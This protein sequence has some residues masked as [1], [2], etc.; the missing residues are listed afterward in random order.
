MA[1]GLSV[2]FTGLE[3]MLRELRELPPQ[4]QQRVIRGATAKGASVL[5]IEAVARAPDLAGPVKPTK[6]H[7][8]PGT[9]KRSIYQTRIPSQCTPTREV[10][11]VDVRKGKRATKSINGKAVSV[12]AFYASWV[13]YGHY[14]RVPHDMTKVARAAGRALGVAK[15]VPAHPFMRPALQA[16]ANESIEAMRL[17]VAQQLPLAGAAMRY[18]E[19]NVK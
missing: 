12:D 4:I 5:R 6:N 16:K 18:L 11:R 19:F 1:D 8:P 14:A 2:S 13:E 9:L 7:P 15:W 10:F 17:Y 3:E